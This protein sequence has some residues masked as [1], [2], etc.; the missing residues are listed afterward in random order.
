MALYY[1]VVILII[2]YL[3][4]RMYRKRKIENLKTSINQGFKQNFQNELKRLGIDD[5][6]RKKYSGT[7]KKFDYDYK[8]V[9]FLEEMQNSSLNPFLVTVERVKK[10]IV[11]GKIVPTNKSRLLNFINTTIPLNKEI[12]NIINELDKNDLISLEQLEIIVENFKKYNSIFWE[13]EAKESYKSS[14][15]D[16]EHGLISKEELEKRRRYYFGDEEN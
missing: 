5:E 10:N 13:K 6:F 12:K 16:Y 14:Y 1:A 7:S 11:K 4:K 15:N 9:S 2:F 3:I 8:G